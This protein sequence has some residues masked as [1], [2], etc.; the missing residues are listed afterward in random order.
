MSKIYTGPMR[1]AHRGVVQAAPE[2]TLGAFKAAIDQGYEGIELDIRMSKDG[3]VIVC[4]DSHFTRMTVGHPTHPSIRHLRDMTTEEILAMELPYANHLLPVKVPKEAVVEYISSVSMQTT[5]DY[6]EAYKTEPRM[7]HLSTFRQFDAWL[8]QQYSDITVEVEFCDPG[9]IKPVMDIVSASPCLRQYILFSGHKD[10][11]N[12]MQAF[13]AKEGKPEGLRMGANIRWLTDEN[14]EYIRGKDFFELGL[15]A[16]DY[17][18]DDVKYLNDRGIQVLSNLGDY[19]EWWSKLIR[20]GA[21]G[22]KTNYA[23]SYT[24]W[25]NENA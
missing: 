1:F 20:T 14:K 3:E 8:A 24:E 2:N 13:I 19:P 25:W 23:Q 18:A 15:N 16:G 5:G 10:I 21:L 6:E 7:A 4:H 9:E 11:I 22:F 17:T 12:E